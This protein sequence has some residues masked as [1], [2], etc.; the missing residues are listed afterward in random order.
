M[1]GWEAELC[2]FPQVAVGVDADDVLA[3]GP[4]A[5]DVDDVNAVL[6]GQRGTLRH[7]GDPMGTGTGTG[8]ILTHAESLK[9][10]SGSATVM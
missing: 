6:E 4:A 9:A 8:M 2:C 1:E 3:E 7:H 10:N 5:G